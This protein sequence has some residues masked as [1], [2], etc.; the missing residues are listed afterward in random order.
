ML[1]PRGELEFEEPFKG[2]LVHDFNIL[3]KE[4]DACWECMVSCQIS[5]A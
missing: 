4:I 5:S 3:V 1:T 2:I